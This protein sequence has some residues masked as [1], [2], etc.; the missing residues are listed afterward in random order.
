[1]LKQLLSVVTLVAEAQLHRKPQMTTDSDMPLLKA[2]DFPAA[3][4]LLSRLPVP[5]DMVRAQARGAQA[6]W[7]YPL[8]GLLLGLLAAL[9]GRLALGLGLPPA[10]VAIVILAS[11]I[12]MT[13]AMHEDGLA[14]SA[15]GLWG[16]W[17]RGRRLEIMKDSH[18]G[19]Y[20][21][22]ALGLSLIARWAALTALIEGGVLFASVMAAACLS[23]VPMVVLM[24]ALP[25]ARADGLSA[26]VG[27]PGARTVWLALALG[28]AFGLLMIGG[29]VFVVIFWLAIVGLTVALIA[30]SK[31]GGQTGD[32][33][34]AMQQLSEIAVLA[35]LA[36][37]WT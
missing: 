4:G 5:V 21:V 35:V 31:I 32:I 34:G 19:T 30:K 22:L 17:E 10:L 33:L 11:L 14:D 23:R 12:L 18:I 27:Q 3:L 25:Q 20:G 8:V 16:G 15:D 13:G 7:A 36:S 6:A 26:K 1:M 29:S 24:A 2:Q 37:A 9:M 28:A